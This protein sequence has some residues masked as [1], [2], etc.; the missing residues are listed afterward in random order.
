MDLT[1]KNIAYGGINDHI[2]GGLHRYTVDSIWH[3]PHFEKMLYDNAQMLSVFSRAYKRNN[4]KVYKKLVDDIFDFVENNL[5]A[6][7]DLIFSS[8]SAVTEIGKDKIEGTIMSGTKMKSRLFL[9]M[10]LNCFQTISIL[11]KFGLWEKNKYVLK[12]INDD[13]FYTKKYNLSSKTLNTKISESINKLRKL[14][15][16]REKP[17]IDEKVLTSWNA[18]TVI[19]LSNA[20]QSTGEKK[21]IDKAMSIVSAIEENLVNDDL[22]EK[23]IINW[24]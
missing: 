24:K 4:D 3:I 21:F 5:T 18:L 12:R 11:I 10:I 17:I 8:I 16:N 2:D 20:F 1:L 7:N 13:D 22:I 14:K 23:I 15:D 9:R 19:G 6:N